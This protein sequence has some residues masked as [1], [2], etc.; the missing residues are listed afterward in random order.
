MNIT[1][2]HYTII[3]VVIGLI[4]VWYFFL[5][6]KPVE[7]N[8]KAATRPISLSGGGASD[9]TNCPIDCQKSQISTGVTGCYCPGRG[10]I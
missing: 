2:K 8:F 4:A 6:K 3:A 9:V 7:S 5:R 1:K 10:W